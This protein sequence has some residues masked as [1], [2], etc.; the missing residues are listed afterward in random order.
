L[1]K[2]GG[3]RIGLQQ[4]IWTQCVEKKIGRRKVTRWSGGKKGSESQS[5]VGE[6]GGESRKKVTLTHSLYTRQK[7]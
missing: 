4:T 6:S 2:G 7:G 3:E 5:S 1:G